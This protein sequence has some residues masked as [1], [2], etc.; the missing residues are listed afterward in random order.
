MVGTRY[1]YDFRK[2]VT[3]KEYVHI[4]STST[5][6]FIKNVSSDANLK[7]ARKS[8]KGQ[9]YR[10]QRAEIE[11]RLTDIARE[12]HGNLP[13]I[14][15]KYAREMKKE[16]IKEKIR[17]EE[18]KVEGKKT[19]GR[20]KETLEE[21]VLKRVEET[22]GYITVYRYG[23]AIWDLS[24]AGQSQTG[25]VLTRGAGTYEG[26]RLQEAIEDVVSEIQSNLR[27]YISSINDLWGRDPILD[28]TED[29]GICIK[30][31]DRA[32][33]VRIGDTYEKGAG[34]RRDRLRAD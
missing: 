21:I 10:A 14:R 6:K 25:R 15:E 31:I 9:V 29:S 7:K 4:T 26:E 18:A 12:R 24:E 11:S 32:T 23:I 33:S 2:D 22:T 34:C 27:A 8:V 3:G 5:G 19:R 17:R 20:K 28:V 13:D 16:K 1:T 30:V